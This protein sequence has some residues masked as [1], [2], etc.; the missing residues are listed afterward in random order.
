M[1]YKKDTVL[2]VLNRSE[3]G[4]IEMYCMIYDTAILIS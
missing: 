3:L 4:F 2:E 1:L